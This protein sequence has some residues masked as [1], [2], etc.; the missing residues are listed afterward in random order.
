MKKVILLALCVVGAGACQTDSFDVEAPSVAMMES[1]ERVVQTAMG[2]VGETEQPDVVPQDAIRKLIRTVDLHL[3]AA[4]TEA[5]ADQLQALSASAGGYIASQSR[6]RHQDVLYFRIT[7]RVPVDSLEGV[8]EKIKALAVRV[9]RE[10]MGTE[11]VTD[12]FVDLEARLRS[13]R[14]TE[15]ELQGLL[16]ESRA[17]QHKVEDIMAI[18]RELTEIRSRIEQI[19]GQRNVLENR[20]SLSTIN[21]QLSPTDAA[22]PVVDDAW[23]PGDTVRSSL[24][25]LLDLGQG[26]AR[27]LIFCL[28]VIVPTVVFGALL[29]WGGMKL[30][31]R[32]RPER[33]G[34]LSP[35]ARPQRV[36]DEAV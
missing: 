4:D 15:T 28:I 23:R 7:L 5:I 29:F 10:Q 24:R 17:R 6:E 19:Q 25:T 33:Q 34:G 13:L 11:D 32:F 21:I 8:L 36:E 22:R 14:A 1:T 30:W 18:Y 31:R 27:F 2:E 3:E 12:R 16:S 20:A 35:S 26:L 9:S